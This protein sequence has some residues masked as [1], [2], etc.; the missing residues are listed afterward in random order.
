MPRILFCLLC[1]SVVGGQVAYGQVN[2]SAGAPVKSKA[3]A[4]NIA[5]PV[6]LDKEANIRRFMQLTGG[7]TIGRDMGNQIKNLLRPTVE[8]SLPPGEYRSKL[9]DLLLERFG[10]RFTSEVV[11]PTVVSVYA[12]RFSDEELKE[13]IAFYESPLGKKA[14]SVLSDIDAE[15]Q[16]MQ[17][18]SEKL[19]QECMEQV[20]AEHPDLKEAMEKASR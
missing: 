20:L 14:A 10:A 11:M 5:Q 6:S 16:K 7:E 2:P 4:T 18:P 15:S 9:V 8:S 1:L 17:E 3:V 19:L 13:L 12:K